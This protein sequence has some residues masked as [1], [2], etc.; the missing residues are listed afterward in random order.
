MSDSRNGGEAQHGATHMEGLRTC[1]MLLSEVRELHN[2]FGPMSH[3][4]S[5]MN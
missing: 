5:L 1:S 4:I 3:E 2:L